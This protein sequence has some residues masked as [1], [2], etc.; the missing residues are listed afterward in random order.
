LNGD[1]K[2]TTRIGFGGKSTSYKSQTEDNIENGKEDVRLTKTPYW[3][4]MLDR[5][6][7]RIEKRPMG[8]KS[9]LPQEV[10]W[11]DV[12]TRGLQRRHNSR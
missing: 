1:P 8:H 4:L 5:R 10:V 12:W 6:V 7:L 2:F 11:H 9:F 3:N